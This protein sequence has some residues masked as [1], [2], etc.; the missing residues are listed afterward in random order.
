MVINVN[1]STL[2][3]ANGGNRTQT[4]D[5]VTCVAANYFVDVTDNGIYIYNGPDNYM[6][7]GNGHTDFI[8][9]TVTFSNLSVLTSLQINGTLTVT[10]G[11][12][13]TGPTTSANT[14]SVLNAGALITSGSSN[15][16]GLEI[17]NTTGGGNSAFTTGIY[18][19]D[20]QA[21]WGIGSR[22][23][24]YVGT[25]SGVPTLDPIVTVASGDALTGKTSYNGLVV[26]ANTG[27][28]TT[29]TWN[30]TRINR[31]SYLSTGTASYVIVNDGSGNMTETSYI[32]I[33]QGGTG[34]STASA[35][36]NALSPVTTLGD[37][38][39]GSAANTN[40]RLAGNITTTMQVLAQ[41]GNG[42]VSAVPAWHTMTKG[43]IGLGS[44]ENTALSTWA[45][46]SYITTLGT[47]TSGTW[48]SSTAITDTYLATLSTAGKVN[49]GCITTG[50]IG[51]NTIINTSGTVTAASF[52]TTTGK[53]GLVTLVECVVPS[54]G[55]AQTTGGT[56]NQIA[57]T[58]SPFTPTAVP[59]IVNSSWTGGY[60]CFVYV[61]GVLY[62]PDSNSSALD[63]DYWIIDTT[64]IRFNEDLAQGAIIQLVIFGW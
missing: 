6:K 22:S 40:S 26:T 9:Q 57:T 8:G 59:F 62:R 17:D 14:I 24:A 41:T 28:I 27:V 47:I 15:V 29:G 3:T 18:Y 34:Q 25:E 48:N 51:G 39:Y 16:Y 38:I 11:M 13:V 64:H 31:N 2:T 1:P 52:T 55:Y 33:A 4:F 5:S 54:G 56:N 61:D 43:D 46:T 35:G 45:G 10:G 58:A 50:T 44:V 30:A 19:K 23:H 36:F 7:F 37:L 21:R 53:V 60:Q 63:K 49:G 32:T 20:S 42:T 12:V